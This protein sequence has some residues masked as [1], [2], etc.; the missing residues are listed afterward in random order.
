MN[1]GRRLLEK[2]HSLKKNEEATVEESGHIL[3]TITALANEGKKFIDNQTKFEIEEAH[4]MLQQI[5]PELKELEINVVAEVRQE[6]A[7]EGAEG[8]VEQT[9]QQQNSQLDDA[10][11]A[12]VDNLKKELNYWEAEGQ[13]AV[14][15]QD[16]LKLINQVEKELSNKRPALKKVKELLTSLQSIT[17]KK[18]LFSNFKKV[19]TGLET[20]SGLEVVKKEK[21]VKLNELKSK[22]DMIEKMVIK[23]TDVQ[24]YLNEIDE[25]EQYSK[26]GVNEID[27]W[28]REKLDNLKNQLAEWSK[29]INELSSSLELLSKNIKKELDS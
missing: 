18:T 15:V 11:K 23:G 8:E 28:S 14:L 2:V 20:I 22:L 12:V 16:K 27:Q 29:K 5:I 10:Y 13:I 3:N 7:L 6:T 9:V 19:K 4:Q 21:R 17:R 25:I 24:S 1:I 26:Q